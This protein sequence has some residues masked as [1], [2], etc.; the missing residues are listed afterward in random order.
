MCFGVWPN[1]LYGYPDSYLV[2]LLACCIGATQQRN[3]YGPVPFRC[4]GFSDRKRML[5][6][7]ARNCSAITEAYVHSL[8][9]RHTQPRGRGLL[10]ILYRL[11]YER[12]HFSKHAIKSSVSISCRSNSFLRCHDFLPTVVQSRK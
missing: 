7:L 8:K 1:R 3:N 9:L 12:R 4:I 11:L 6:L 2:V 10:T 5:V